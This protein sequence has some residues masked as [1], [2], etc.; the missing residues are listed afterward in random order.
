MLGE[1][2]AVRQRRQGRTHASRHDRRPQLP[3][4]NVGNNDSSTSYANATTFEYCM[5]RVSQSKTNRLCRRAPAPQPS[6]T[7]HRRRPERQQRQPAP[8]APSCSKR[9]FPIVIQAYV[10]WLRPSPR[11]PAHSLICAPSKR[12]PDHPRHDEQTAR[13]LSRRI[14]TLRRKKPV[15]TSFEGSRTTMRPAT[16][17]HRHHHRQRPPRQHA[18]W[19][20]CRKWHSGAPPPATTPTTLIR[21]IAG[22]AALASHTLLVIEAPP[23]ALQYFHTEWLAP[24]GVAQDRHLR[25]VV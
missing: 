3:Q 16:Q 15:S 1:R 19:P 25:P 17:Q 5:P 14:S 4:T 22:L 13:L 21:S 2:I 11:Q 10:A 20:I 23:T 7:H 6:T 18:P 12:R 8:S 9:R 24:A